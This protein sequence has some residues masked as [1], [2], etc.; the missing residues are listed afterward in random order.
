MSCNKILSS[1]LRLSLQRNVFFGLAFIIELLLFL[2]SPSL[3]LAQQRS[4]ASAASPIEQDVHALEVGKPIERELAGG[5]THIYQLPLEANQF[6]HVLVDQRGIDVKITL[7][8]PGSSQ[9]I[10]DSQNGDYGHEPVLWIAPVAGVYLLELSA[11]KGIGRYQINLVALQAATQKERTLAQAFKLYSQSVSLEL[12]L[13][14]LPANQRNYDE[15][16]AVGESARQMQEQALGTDHPD[17]ALTLYHLAILY[18]ARAMPPADYTQAE[19]LLRRAIKNWEK[20][21]GNEHLGL[22]RPLN[23]LAKVQKNAGNIV[24]EELLYDRVRKM[25]EKLLPDDHRDLAS[26]RFNLGEILGR[27]REFEKAEELLKK[28]LKT[29]V[30]MNGPKDPSAINCRA[31]LANTYVLHDKY[32]QAET[33]FQEQ[34]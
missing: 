20:E 23:F 14:Q 3:A 34:L 27:K 9:I 28:A 33:L 8:M 16:I 24:Q 17:T 26:A 2:T 22:R 5:Q 30:A 7:T 4:G 31:V 25:C 11:Q 29:F 6:A 10:A 18:L 19:L 12:A 13:R 32:S 1:W 15:A 21:W